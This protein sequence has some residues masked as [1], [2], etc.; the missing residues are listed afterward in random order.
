MV[1]SLFGVLIASSVVVTLSEE[2][3]VVDPGWPVGALD[4]GEAA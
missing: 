2:G 4:R 3:F 1:K